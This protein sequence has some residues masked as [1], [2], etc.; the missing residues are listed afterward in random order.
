L[1]TPKR[2]WIWKAK[3]CQRAALSAMCLLV[4]PRALQFF[5]FRNAVSVFFAVSVHAA[6]SDG[7]IHAISFVDVHGRALS[8]A[9][10]HVTVLVLTTTADSAKARAVGDHVPDH[11]LGNP[12]YR[13]ITVVNFKEKH[14]RVVRM[15]GTMMMRHRLDGE[16]KRLQTRYDAKKIAENA[17]HDIFAVADFDGTVSSQL[18]PSPES[19]D[20]HVFV[21]GKKGELLQRWDDVPNAEELAAVLR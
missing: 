8:T 9:D 5:F 17:R 18:V 15:I 3:T 14:A 2:K 16:A 19:V 4:N 21:F 1:A 13:M 7:Q 12:D 6:S 11:C 10:G 20:F